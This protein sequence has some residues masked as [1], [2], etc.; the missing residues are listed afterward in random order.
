MDF[1]VIGK[2]SNIETIAVNNSI[3]EID[4]LRKNYG[5]GSWKKCKGSAM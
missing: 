2:I 3:R 5:D 1:D 4:R